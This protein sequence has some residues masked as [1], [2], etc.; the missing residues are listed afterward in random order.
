MI[1]GDMF[2][3]S[4]AENLQDLVDQEQTWI[5][6]ILVPEY[7]LTFYNESGRYLKQF[8]AKEY[9]TAAH[10]NQLNYFAFQ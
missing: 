1:H 9:T 7:L 3:A 8:F 10:E 5:N 2:D 6:Q 4:G